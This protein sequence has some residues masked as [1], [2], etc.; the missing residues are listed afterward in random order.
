MGGARQGQGMARVLIVSSYVASGHVGLSASGAVLQALGHD[1]TGLPTVVLSNHLG[2][3]HVAGGP[4]PVSQLR[5]MAGALRANGLLEDHDAVLVGYLP[6]PDHVAFAADLVAEMRAMDPA[7]RIVVDPILGDA[8]GGL[9]VPEAVARAVRERL[10]PLADTLTPNHFELG[11]LTGRALPDLAATLEAAG[12]LAPE[13]LVT[14]PP[15]GAEVTGLLAVRGRRSALFRTLRRGGV[16]HGVGDSFAAMIAAGM[17]PGEALGRLDALVLCSIGA[18]HL[19][20]A[21]S[22]PR[23]V[24]APAIGPE[25]QV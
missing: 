12:P 9:Y 6:S 10:V 14:S 18:P 24:A 16:P 3:A 1:V 22:A 25:S 23:W 17:A 8:P 5:D 15:L 4:L 13:V 7:P 19:A 2:W 11:W 21:T 20:I